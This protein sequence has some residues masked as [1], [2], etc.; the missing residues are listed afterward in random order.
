[1]EFRGRK[2]CSAVVRQSDAEIAL[3]ADKV[4]GVAH[5]FEYDVVGLE[6]TLAFCDAVD[7]GTIA[8]VRVAVE[9]IAHIGIVVVAF[10][11]R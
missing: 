10:F 2:F 3:L 7:V 8:D 6:A 11:A 4:A 1:M 9:E 5:A